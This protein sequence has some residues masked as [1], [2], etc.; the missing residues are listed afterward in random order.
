MVV[1]IDAL[2][3]LISSKHVSKAEDQALREVMRAA[4]LERPGKPL[5]VKNEPPIAESL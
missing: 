1:G 4:L 3:E 5:S 2:A